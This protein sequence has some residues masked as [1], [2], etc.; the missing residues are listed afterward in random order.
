MLGGAGHHSKSRPLKNKVTSIMTCNS[1]FA[2]NISGLV[3]ILIEKH[4]KIAQT[5]LLPGAITSLFE[6]RFKQT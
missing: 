6:F 4:K 2:G 5:P 1:W 3:G